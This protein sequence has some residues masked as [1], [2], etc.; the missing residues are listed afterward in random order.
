M[1]P[2]CDYTVFSMASHTFFG[3]FSGRFPLLVGSA[4]K[5]V[6][7]AFS[8]AIHYI[9]P[10]LY[11]RY[12]IVERL[13]LDLSLVSPNKKTREE[14]MDRFMEDQNIL[15]YRRL[16]NSSTGETERRAILKLLAE[17]M[18]DFKNQL[19]KTNSASRYPK[20]SP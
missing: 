19:S 16:R 7:S 8:G 9:V 20:A 12:S 13:G 17:V 14:K 15:L 5:S 10:N 4:C 2:N 18:D 3:K 1:L 6:R 11:L